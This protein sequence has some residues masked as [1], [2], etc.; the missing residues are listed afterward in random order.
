[1]K[2]ERRKPT[3]AEWREITTPGLVVRKVLDRG[4][5]REVQR[6][7]TQRTPRPRGGLGMSTIAE[8]RAKAEREIEKIRAN[9]DLSAE[10]KRRKIQE[11]YERSVAEHRELVEE[12]RRAEAEAIASA[13]RKVLGIP[14]PERSSAS[15]R[16]MIAL[17]YR[18]ALDRAERAASDR[19]D[20]G[21]LLDLLERAEVSG[22]S[23]LARAVYHTATRRGV[24]QVADA[25]LASRPTEQA[26][27]E[28]YMQVRNEARYSGGL[29]GLVLAGAESVR[30]A[31]PAELRAG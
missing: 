4:R 18:D 11:V 13:E 28:R 26:R 7:R 9:P 6:E 17:S 24:R 15:E 27:W 19:E 5:G 23:L 14:Y 20:L 31:K 21:A 22:D 16:A 29:E 10:A 12:E 25:Y 8:N 3:Q 30:P 1:M 2:R